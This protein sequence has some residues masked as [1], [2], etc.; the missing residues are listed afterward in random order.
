MTESHFLAA[1]AIK[2]TLDNYFQ[3]KN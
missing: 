1:A 2:I 3:V